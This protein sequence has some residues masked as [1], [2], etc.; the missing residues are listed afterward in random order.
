MFRPPSWPAGS[1][2]NFA[3]EG[4]DESQTG[5]LVGELG[6]GAVA[7]DGSRQS[8][9]PG[10]LVDEYGFTLGCAPVV[11][12]LAG[13]RGACVFCLPPALVSIEGVAVLCEAG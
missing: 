10:A 9:P 11:A 13:A 2:L 7:W 1:Q 6:P 4:C 5:D 12:D 3:S 8:A